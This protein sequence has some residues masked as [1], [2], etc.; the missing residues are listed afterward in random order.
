MYCRWK[1]RETYRSGDEG[2]LLPSSKDYQKCLLC[3]IQWNLPVTMFGHE[4]ALIAETGKIDYR[5]LREEYSTSC[6]AEFQST[7]RV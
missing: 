6:I 2:R 7:V 1:G 5:G 4:L 3:V